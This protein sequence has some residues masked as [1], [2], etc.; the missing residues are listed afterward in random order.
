MV[1]FR[2]T[3]WSS[4]RPRSRAPSRH[5]PERHSTDSGRPTGSFAVGEADRE[6]PGLPRCVEDVV[7]ISTWLVAGS[8]VTTEECGSCEG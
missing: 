8:Y 7:A 1:E 5:R 6:T 3:S 4:T 2:L